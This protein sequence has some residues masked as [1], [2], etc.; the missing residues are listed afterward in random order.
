MQNITEFQT[1]SRGEWIKLLD[2]LFPHG[3]PTRASWD[4]QAAICAVLNHLGTAAQLHYA[5]LPTHGGLNLSGAQPNGST[6]LTELYL[7]SQVWICQVAN[8]SFESFGDRN[9]Y[10]WCY[11]RIELGALPAVPE[12]QPEG[13]GYYQRLTELAPGQY[14]PPQD[15]DNRFEEESEYLK[16]AR[17]VLRYLKGSI[18]LFKAPSVYDA[19]D[20]STSAAHEPLSADAFRNRVEL[21][22]NHIRQTGPHTTK[23]RLDSILLHGDMQPE[24]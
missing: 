15:F 6:G 24:L 3:L 20:H 11:F 1:Q 10:Q 23:S 8:L 12:S 21:L 14:L 18:V 5:F 16:S 13:N 17:L 4:D 2:A 22:R 19:L 9:D 7:G